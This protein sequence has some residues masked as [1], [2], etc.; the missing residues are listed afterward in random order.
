M[1]AEFLALVEIKSG[2]LEVNQNHYT[3]LRR[4][5]VSTISGKFKIMH[6]RKINLPFLKKV[7]FLMKVFVSARIPKYDRR[8][9]ELFLSGRRF[10]NSLISALIKSR[11]FF[12]R[13][14]GSGPSVVG[15]DI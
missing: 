15:C 1:R 2:P 8:S 10:C 5:V 14:L 3:E 12:E 13:I 9:R 11:L 7:A 4:S 6:L